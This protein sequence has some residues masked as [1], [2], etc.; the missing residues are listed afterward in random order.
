MLQAQ[1][2]EQAASRCLRCRS[3]LQAQLVPVAAEAWALLGL[4]PQPGRVGRLASRSVAALPPT[5]LLLPLTAVAVAVE[6]VEAVL[7]ARSSPPVFLMAWHPAGTAMEMAR[8][9]GQRPR[10]NSCG[11][12]VAA[13]Q[14]VGQAGGRGSGRAAEAPT[15]PALLLEALELEVGLAGVLAMMMEMAIRGWAGQ[16]RSRIRLPHPHP[17]RQFRRS[18]VFR[19]AS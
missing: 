3:P 17:Q 18:Q 15:H 16:A 2:R 6:A 13:A 10:P 4:P 14:L 5:E 1:E 19:A 11:S 9:A 12:E 7:M 8:P